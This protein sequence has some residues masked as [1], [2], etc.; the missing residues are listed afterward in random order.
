MLLLIAQEGGVA[1]HTILAYLIRCI[2]DMRVDSRSKVQALQCRL[3]PEYVGVHK[4]IPSYD[5]YN[6]MG[7]IDV[8]ICTIVCLAWHAAHTLLP[9]QTR[10]VPLRCHL[11]A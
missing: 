4:I 7:E 2:S 1:R 9:S 11:F 5:D 3:R 6:T 10:P 8:Y